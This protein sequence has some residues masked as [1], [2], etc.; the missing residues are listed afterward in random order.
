MIIGEGPGFNEVRL[1]LPFVGASGQVVDKVLARIGRPRQELAINNATLCVPS[2]GSTPDDRERAAIACSGRLQRD[3]QQFPGIPI[4]TLGAIAARSVIPKAALDAIDPPDVPASKK[5]IAK[6]KQKAE[7]KETKKK[8]KAIE[9]IAVRRFNKAVKHHVGQIVREYK[10]VRKARPDQ[11]WI[12]TQVAH[13]R[14]QIR[15]KCLKDAIAEYE[16]NATAR[17]LAKQIKAAERAKNP[18]AKKKK[19]IKITDIMGSAFEVDV[20]GTGIRVVIP[21]IHPAALLRGGGATIGGTHAPDLAFVN[22]IYD[23]GKVDKLSQG[24]DIWL[25]FDAI[26]IEFTDAERATTLFLDLIWEALEEG[27]IGI[28]LET[29]V[30]DPDRHHALMA[31]VAK[32]RALGLSTK[33]RAI[34]VFWD[35]LPEWCHSFLQLALSKLRVIAHNGLYDRTVLR[36]RGFILNEIWADTLLLHAAAF[37]GVSHRLQMV[38]SQL[39]A[40]EPWKAE[41]RNQEETP[42]KLCLYNAKDTLSTVRDHAP[43]EILVRRNKAER[44]YA[45]DAKMSEIASR[46]HLHGMPVSREVNTEMVTRFSALSTES[47]RSVEEKLDDPKTRELVLHHLAI[48]QGQKKRKADPDT[49]EERYQLRLAVLEEEKFKWKISSGKH[50][51]ALLMALG[52]SLNTKTEGGD[53]STKKEILESL[54][55]IG[56][57]R[58]ILRFREA[59]KA[60]NTFFWPTFDRE[61]D[62]KIVKYGFADQN[63]RVHPIWSLPK[64]SGRWSSWDPVVSNPLKDIWKKGPDGKKFLQRPSS[65]RQFVCRPGRMLVGFDFAQLEAR[66]IALISGDPFLLWVFSTGRDIHT[67]CARGI[68]DGQGGSVSFDAAGTA[69]IEDLTF[70]RGERSSEQTRMRN[71]TK[72]VE[73]GSFYGGSMETLWKT[74]LKEGFNIKLADV[75]MAVRK[76]QGKMPGVVAWQANTIRFASMPPYQLVDYVDGRRRVW[77]LGQVDPNEALNIVPQATGAAIMNT[78]MERMDARIVDRGYKQAYPIV[79]V[80]DAAVYE[81]WEDDAD[82]LMQDLDDCF[83]Q[84]YERDGVKIPFPIDKKKG[85]CWKDV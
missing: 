75:E 31:Y 78:G 70:G 47:R 56:V 36:A 46:M 65:K 77:P 27:E 81:C 7:H 15:A 35:L 25:R 76:L 52:V 28:D 6:E 1:G 30:D 3:L 24:K 55:D 21:T 14:G 19:P 39:F 45:R 4:L 42:D 79:Q 20:D 17:E 84:E 64:I 72:N 59:D 50:I 53:I 68:F 26:D 40:V 58:D 54:A 10:R 38:T 37:P 22:L 49:F 8:Q 66:I 11:T 29:Y 71:V 5:K 16:A 57:V 33:N 32:I 48:Q 44:A 2:F 62:G 63:D 73:Y 82:D 60:L 67:E 34:S 61:V 41:Y 9:K 18:K 69:L 85:T 74:L 23:A 80:H 43:L 51:A 83:P 12:N 13:V